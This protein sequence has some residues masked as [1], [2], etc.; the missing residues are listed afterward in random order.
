[1]P[2]HFMSDAAGQSYRRKA[3][4]AGWRALDNPEAA[5]DLLRPFFRDR[6]REHVCALFLNAEGQPC[7]MGTWAGEQ[8][9]VD[10]PLRQVFASGLAADAAAM[11]IAHNHPS[12]DPTPGPED[13]RTTRDLARIG[14][15]LGIRLVDHLVIAG[16]RLTS[17]R[18]MRL[19]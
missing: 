8:G 14:A 13:L 4:A 3:D 6:S 17:M 12:G 1:M 2:T 15:M 10:L 7:A 19:I 9:F 5:F 16:E 18:A 11:I